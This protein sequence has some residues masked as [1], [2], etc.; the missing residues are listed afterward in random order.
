MLNRRLNTV[1]AASDI[2]Q[3]V[4]KDDRKQ[5]FNYLK[6]ACNVKVPCLNI[7]KTT[8]KFRWGSS[9]LVSPVSHAAAVPSL[10]SRKYC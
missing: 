9:S 10:I 1:S 8:A 7:V 2:G 6:A 4:C 3:L 5:W